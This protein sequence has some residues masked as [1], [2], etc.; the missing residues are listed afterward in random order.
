MQQ[1]YA[2]VDELESYF[3]GR[4]FTTDGHLVGSIG[5]VLAAAHYNLKLL[6]A[7][8]ETHDAVACDGKMV[9]I[10][11]TQGKSVGIRSEP[12]HLIV[13]KI[14]KDGTTTELYNGPGKIAWNNSG[15]MQKNGQKN[16]STS[17]L[18]QLMK[19]ICLSNRLP[20]VSL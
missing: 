2:I 16:I 10:K 5:E 20:H 7:S 8:I 4:H 9:Q 12:E 18:T 19:S 6:P 11:V 3:P 13:L 17:K 14:L 1:L 15:N